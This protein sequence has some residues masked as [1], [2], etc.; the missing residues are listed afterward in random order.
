MSNSP[1]STT[2]DEC[3]HG[4]W[5]PRLDVDQHGAV[6]APFAGRVFLDPDHR[7][8]ATSGSGRASTSRRTV[9]RLTATP[10]TPAIR[11]PARPASARPTTA[12]V[13]RRCSV[14]R[15]YRRVG[16]AL[17]STKV[18]RL[19]NVF[20]QMNRRT[21]RHSRTRFP[22]TWH[23]SGIPHVGAVNPLR[24]AP[25]PNALGPGHRAPGLYQYR[26][27]VHIDR[28]HRDIRD[29]REQQLLRPEHHLFHGPELSANPRSPRMI[30][31]Q[32]HDGQWGLQPSLTVH[33]S[34]KVS[35]NRFS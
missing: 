6:E 19:H 13:D 14:H 30:L 26:L 32:P 7:G 24:P 28:H 35:L 34:R 23:V 3:Q 25:A 8:A 1:L 4:H 12:S 33:A 10:K 11:A 9:L 22:A 29:R 21:H 5:S 17:C 15:P 18:R 16:P 2:S 27:I 31:R 20:P